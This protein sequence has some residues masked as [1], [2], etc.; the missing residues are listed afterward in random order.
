MSSRSFFVRKTLL[1]GRMD[2]WMDGRKEGWMEAKA[3][4]TI[5]YSNQK[6]DKRQ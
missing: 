5:A 1:D 4:L 2:G 3:G 6:L